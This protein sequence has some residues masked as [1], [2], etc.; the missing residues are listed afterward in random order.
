MRRGRFVPQ[1][2]EACGGASRTFAGENCATIPCVLAR[3]A[4]REQPDRRLWQE[5]VRLSNGQRPRIS[6]IGSLC[7]GFTTKPCVVAGFRGEAG[8]R[9]AL[10]S[11]RN[12]FG[13]IHCAKTHGF[14]TKRVAQRD[15]W[16][17]D[18]ASGA[19]D[20][21]DSDCCAGRGAPGAGRAPF[22]GRVTVASGVGDWAGADCWAGDAG[23]W[24]GDA[25]AERR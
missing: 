4:S 6:D 12:L 8:A 17:S 3:A 25:D 2:D 23:G 24:A 21:A 11:S 10:G 1:A 19:G 18:G 9:R 14:V 7:H 16:A 5:T 15:G 13:D 20:Q 22:A